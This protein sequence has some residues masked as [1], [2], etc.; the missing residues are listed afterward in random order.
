MRGITGICSV[1]L[2]V[3]V[4][5][6]ALVLAGGPTRS[7]PTRRGFDTLQPGSL[8]D[9]W[10]VE[11]TNRRAQ[12]AVWKVGTD[13]AAPSP[14]RVLEALPQPDNFGGA[15]NLCWTDVV[16]FLDGEIEV[17]L[18]ANTGQ[19]DQGGGPIWRVKDRNNY[20]IARYNPL[21]HNFRLYIVKDGARR[22]LDS[23]SRIEIPARQWFTIRIVQEA[24]HIQGW[25]D[26]KK[27]LDVHEGT[28]IRPGGVGL[29]TK[30]D[31]ATS[32]DDFMVR[33]AGK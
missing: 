6:A 28:F 27:L 15:Y 7:G 32:F 25:L 2:V 18:R 33:P 3:S 26:G 22:M 30:A 19:E 24:D 16:R 23:A 13:P 5:A 10:K 17:K 12:P 1:L 9:G 21:E 14:T 8:P 11:A 4:A 20:Y 31:A 29:W